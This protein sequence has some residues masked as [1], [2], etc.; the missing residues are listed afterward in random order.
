MAEGETDGFVKIVADK[1]SHEILGVHIVGPGA[2][3]LVSEGALA[4]E[5]HA[6]LE[7]MALT[8]HPHPTFGEAMMETALHGLGQAVH[9]MNR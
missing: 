7:D 3:D 6:F 9:I 1:A 5:M 2:T 4:L 8:I